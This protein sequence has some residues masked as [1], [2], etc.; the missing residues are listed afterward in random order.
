MLRL[1]RALNG[2]QYQ[3]QKLLL[4]VQLT[5]PHSSRGRSEH[6]RDYLP[7]QSEHFFTYIYFYPE[8]S[9]K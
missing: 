6:E 1:L 7:Q 2:K 5:D 8:Y 9:D 3:S 4:G